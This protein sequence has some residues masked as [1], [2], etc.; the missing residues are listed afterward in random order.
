MCMCPPQAKLFQQNYHLRSRIDDMRRTKEQAHDPLVSPAPSLSRRN[1]STKHFK[2]GGGGN[3]TP[4]SVNS[5]GTPVARHSNRLESSGPNWRPSR[6]ISHPVEDQTTNNNWRDQ[7]ITLDPAI[8]RSLRS[9]IA[10]LQRKGLAI[11]RVIRSGSSSR[12]AKQHKQQL[13]KLK[14][15]QVIV[16]VLLFIGIAKA[17]IMLCQHT[18]I[19]SL[20]FRCLSHIFKVFISSRCLC[21]GEFC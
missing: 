3:S 4:Q 13:S 5:H 11:V 17:V 2:H 14:E 16:I 8:Q 1:N 20:L 10:R 15:A 9:N 19:A 7:G 18:G 6:D 21:S 12:T